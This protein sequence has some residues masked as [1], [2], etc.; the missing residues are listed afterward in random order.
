MF[1]ISELEKRGYKLHHSALTR[2][3]QKKGTTTIEDYQGRYG[4]GYKITTHNPQS[5]QYKIVYYYIK[6]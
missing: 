3:Y 6:K 5:S 2:G 1:I 4:K